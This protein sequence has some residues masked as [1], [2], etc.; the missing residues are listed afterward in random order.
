MRDDGGL[1]QVGG[2]EV[3]EKWLFRDIVGF[4]GELDVGCL[5]REKLSLMITFFLEEG[6]VW[7]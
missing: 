5:E 2:S 6:V 4:V 3:G 7:I 1:E